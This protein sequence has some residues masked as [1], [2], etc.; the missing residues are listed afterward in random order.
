LIDGR[1]DILVLVD[2]V[3]EEQHVDYDR[4]TMRVAGYT[5]DRE[6]AEEKRNCFLEAER[7]EKV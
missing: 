2:I 3:I 7:K 6:E 1:K 4:S 5:L